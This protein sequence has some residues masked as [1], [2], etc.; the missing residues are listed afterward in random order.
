MQLSYLE[1]GKPLGTMCCLVDQWKVC[2]RARREVT[3]LP[4]HGVGR[5]T[6]IVANVYLYLCDCS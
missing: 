2:S 5:F 6:G 1:D 3:P 4:L